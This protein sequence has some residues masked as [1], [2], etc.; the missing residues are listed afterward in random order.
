MGN[1]AATLESIAGTLSRSG[2]G[3]TFFELALQ[4]ITAFFIAYLGGLAASLTPCVYPMIPITLGTIGGLGSRTEHKRSS[5][6]VR[7]SS[8][9][10]GMV[11]VYALLGVFA[12][13][14]GRLFGSLTQNPTSYLV[15]G[16]ILSI[17]ALG[18]VGVI[19]FDPQSW[20][21]RLTRRL[22]PGTSR[23]GPNA[24]AAAEELTWVGA[25]L[26][27]MTSGAIASPCTTP[28]LTAILAF[29]AKTQSVGTGLI[30]MTGFGLGL[31]TLLFAVAIFAGSLQRL[32]KAG[33]WMN[34]VK[35]GS[36]LVLLAFG[37]YLF[38]LAG[39]IGTL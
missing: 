1:L 16:T 38:Y 18:M 14:S 15:V 12:A 17:C 3:V 30:L 21:Q 5:L 27:G 11:A 33:S 10:L 7:A 31:G 32:P 23:L 36:A 22:T 26:L 4:L 39:R 13:L 2:D 6:Y 35:T 8:Y 29:I 37:H 28:I 9:V 24:S 20:I 34:L 25:F 19:P